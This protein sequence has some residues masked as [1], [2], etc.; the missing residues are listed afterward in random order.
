MSQ[1]VN[2]C[3]LRPP[4]IHRRLAIGGVRRRAT[5]PASRQGGLAARAA[6]HR[7]RSG[8]RPAT[9]RRARNRGPRVRPLATGRRG[10]VPGR[11][12]GLGRRDADHRPMAIPLHARPLCRGQLARLGGDRREG[13]SHPSPALPGTRE[14][15]P[16][17]VSCSWC[18]SRHEPAT[19]ASVFLTPFATRLTR[20][21]P[22]FARLPNGHSKTTCLFC[23]ITLNEHV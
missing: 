8:H 23:A 10:T 15:W 1:D 9:R 19:T 7:V 17:R 16:Q 5:V 13:R 20:G 22:G 18:L 4:S 12:R 3:G 11:R 14:A 21:G 2:R 6:Q